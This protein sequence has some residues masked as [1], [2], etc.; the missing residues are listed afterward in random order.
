MDFKQYIEKNK[1]QMIEDLQAWIRV[2]SV[3]GEANSDCPFGEGPRNALLQ[4]L[5]SGENLGFRTKNVDNYAGYIEFGEGEEEIGILA[6]VDVVPEGEDWTH[7][8]YGAEIVDD[9]MFGRGTLDDKGPAVAALYAMKAVK[10]SGVALAKRVRLILG[11]NE[12][13]G[14]KGIAYYLTKEK[15]P[16]MGFTPD[17]E[18]PVIYGEKGIANFELS[19]DLEKED[20]SSIIA[21]SGGSEAN[22][23]PE[24]CMLVLNKDDR[25]LKDVKRIK[26]ENV[27]ISEKDDRIEII[28]KGKAAHGSTPWKGKNAVSTLVEALKPVIKADTSF[29]RFLELYDT[30]IGFDFHGERIGCHLSDEESGDLSLNLGVLALNDGKIVMTVNVR[31]P[32]QSVGSEVEKGIEKVLK[33]KELH[34]SGLK[35][36]V[37]PLYIPKEHPLV[38]TLMQVYREETGDIES[39]PITI[40]GGTY[41]RECK[42]MVAFGA[43]FPGDEDTMHQK[44]ES[45]PLERLVRMTKIYAKAIYELAK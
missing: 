12:E 20:R 9:V 30:H 13:H 16:T 1:T 22:M 17:A 5:K 26:R 31:Y 28:A 14:S 23:V 18:F 45:I 38:E 39:Q 19:F 24:C 42:N 6:H 34:F 27:T 10:D 40:G 41:A 15:M 44:D 33:G 43:L 32:I 21:F 3:M 2:K 35:E 7:D 29:G 8:P 37:P 11:T 36:D 4:A 25:L